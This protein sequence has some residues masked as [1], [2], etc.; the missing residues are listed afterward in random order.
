MRK[1]NPTE[2]SGRAILRSIREFV[3]AWWQVDRIRVSPGDGRL[4]NLKPGSITILDGQPVEIVGRTLLNI[5]ES[6][7]V[8]YDCR[9]EQGMVRLKVSATRVGH[10]PVYAWEQSCQPAAD[11][12]ATK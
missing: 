3:R 8:V 10:S 1:T 11:H 5:A 9:I 12:F 7:I 4:W 6:P 2:H